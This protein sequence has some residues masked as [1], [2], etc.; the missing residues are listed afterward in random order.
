MDDVHLVVLACV[1]RGQKTGPGRELGGYVHHFLPSGDQVEGDATS[2]AASALHRPAASRE[3]LS[4]PHERT[5]A[6]PVRGED[7]ILGYDR[8]TCKIR[9]LGYF[10][11]Q[12]C[13]SSNADPFP[14]ECQLSAVGSNAKPEISS[15]R[16]LMRR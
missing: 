4:P 11:L 3:A 16:L 7:G 10:T 9:P 5:Q 12:T 8:D 15:E 14:N 6:G 13:R 2:Q 1:A